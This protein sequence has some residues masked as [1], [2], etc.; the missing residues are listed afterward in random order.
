MRGFLTRSG[1]HG[2]SRVFTGRHWPFNSTS[3]IHCRCPRLHQNSS[4]SVHPLHLS[5]FSRAPVSPGTGS[6]T[7]QARR[8]PHAV[9]DALIS[10]SPVPVGTSTTTKDDP[11]PLASSTSSTS[12]TPAQLETRHRDQAAAAAPASPAPPPR[13]AHPTQDAGG[14]LCCPRPPTAPSS[15]CLASLSTLGSSRR[16]TH[17][18]THAYLRFRQPSAPRRRR[19]VTRPAPVTLL[20]LAVCLSTRS[21]LRTSPL[22]RAEPSAA[23]PPHPPSLGR[24]RAPSQRRQAQWVSA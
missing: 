7:A 24:P 13:A 22:R 16:R 12:S 20:C 15:F 14:S 2:S 18:R 23:S 3:R 4:A 8:T 9:D 21:H 17:A 6:G 10:C 5:I 11:R 19:A 1:L